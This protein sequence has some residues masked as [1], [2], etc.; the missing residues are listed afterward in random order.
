MSKIDPYIALLAVAAI[1]L[2]AGYLLDATRPW[3]EERRR[4]KRRIVRAKRR[5]KLV[6]ARRAEQDRIRQQ[7][8]RKG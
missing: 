4:H 3:R 6:A 8:N 1:M 7:R 5:A 2:G